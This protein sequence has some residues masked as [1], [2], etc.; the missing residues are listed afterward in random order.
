VLNTS[1]DKIAY[2]LWIAG[3]AA[4]LVSRPH[5]IMTVVLF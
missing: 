3:K 2:K 5:S 1:D 4:D